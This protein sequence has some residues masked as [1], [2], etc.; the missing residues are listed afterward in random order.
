[1]HEAMPE[2]T[3][4]E[5]VLKERVHLRKP[6]K[7]VR[8]LY[9]GPEP[10]P[11][12]TVE[13]IER[14]AYE[15]GRAE[16]EEVSKRQIM[17]ARGEMKQLQGEVLASIQNRYEELSH[18]LDE[19]L[20]D[21]V[22]AIV[23]KIWEGMT[24]DRETLIKSIDAALEQIGSGEEKLVLKIS[25]ADEKLLQ[26][27]EHFTARYPNLTIESDSELKSG[28]VVVRSRFGIVDSRISTKIGRVE[29][30]LRRAHQ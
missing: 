14:E 22:L 6:I 3:P 12:A 29:K 9:H 15:R 18:Q 4:Q 21:L 20:P 26:G 13:Q 27:N 28:D 8:I 23:G 7:G 1:M 16:V 5:G 24:I 10:I 19:S 30:E 2:S 11:A 17:Q 25:T